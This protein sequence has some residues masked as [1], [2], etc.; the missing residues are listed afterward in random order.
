VREWEGEVEEEVGEWEGKKVG[1]G[2]RK[3]GGW[4][5]LP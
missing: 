2:G 1:G 4:E 3:G 5:G